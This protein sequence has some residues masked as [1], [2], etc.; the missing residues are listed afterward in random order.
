MVGKGGTVSAG[1]V[2]CPPRFLEVRAGDHELHTAHVAGSLDD[3]VHVAVMDL[4][5][6]ILP[7]ED[8]IT[9]VDPDLNGFISKPYQRESYK[10][11]Y[12]HIS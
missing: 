11:T 3:V 1:N 5:A 12:I 9:K 6:M 8:G 4:S 2:D 7:A 10:E